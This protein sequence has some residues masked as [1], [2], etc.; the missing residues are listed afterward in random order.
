MK[1]LDILS[2]LPEHYEDIDSNNTKFLLKEMLKKKIRYPNYLQKV[3][4][5]ICTM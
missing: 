4:I 5:H 3:L 1:I 2:T